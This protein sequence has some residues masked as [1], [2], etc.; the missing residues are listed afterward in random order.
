MTD[1]FPQ[2]IAAFEAFWTTERTLMFYM[3]YSA[4]V[5]ALPDPDE[6][7]G[8]S[9]LFFYRLT[10]GIAMNINVVRKKVTRTNGANG[11]GS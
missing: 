8:R 10:H 2:W 6:T 9:Y 5:Q 3:L 7:S 1:C 4:F 11:A